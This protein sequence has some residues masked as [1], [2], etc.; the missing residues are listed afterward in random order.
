MQTQREGFVCDSKSESFF[1]VLM[2]AREWKHYRCT[3]IEEK[4]ENDRERILAAKKAAVRGTGKIV[5]KKEPEGQDLE[6]RFLPV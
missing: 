6:R 2:S 1:L 3:F 4:Y 5:K